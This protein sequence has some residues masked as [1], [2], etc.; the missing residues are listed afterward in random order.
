[1]E[2]ELKPCPFCGEPATPG[3]GAQDNFVRCTGCRGRTWSCYD[4]AAK[5]IAAWNTRASD[6]RRCGD[7]THWTLTSGDGLRY[8]KKYSSEV[9]GSTFG[10]KPDF[11]CADFTKRGDK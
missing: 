8:C 9:L 1:M 2:N 7:C 11:F 5:A 3:F 10:T 4:T 6:S